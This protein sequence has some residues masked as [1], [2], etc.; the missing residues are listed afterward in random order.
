MTN[1]APLR[2]TLIQSDLLWEKP[3]ENLEQFSRKLEALYHT[4]DVVLLPEMFTTGFSMN[5][6][7]L[8]SDEAIYKYLDGHSRKGGF[9][10]YGSVMFKASHIYVNRGIFMRPD[11]SKDIY[12]KRHTFTLAGEHEVYKRGEKP[13]TVTYLGW[14]INLQI[15]YDLRFPVFSRNVQDYDLII[16][17]ANWPVPRINAWD[18]LLKARAIENMSYC[19]GVNRTGT[20]GTGMNYN[21]HSQVYDVL[22]NE[23]CEY[24]WETQG[25]KTVVLEKKHVNYYRNKLKF[26]QDRDGFTL[27]HL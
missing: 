19:V 12:D 22:G 20:D 14:K 15:C 17:I 11:G 5:P 18:A 26:L 9:A 7:G 27:S 8:A 1:P 3:L 16:Y 13:V 4:T 6:K 2:V 23:L 25:E 21:G 10:I 24:P